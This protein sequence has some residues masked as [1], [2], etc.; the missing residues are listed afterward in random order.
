MN[1]VKPELLEHL[2][3][4]C[5][6][7]HRASGMRMSSASSTICRWSLVAEG[8]KRFSQTF[9]V[10]SPRR[11]LNRLVVVAVQIDY[12]AE[13]THVYWG[14]IRSGVKLVAAKWRTLAH[15]AFSHRPLGRVVPDRED[16]YLGLYRRGGRRLPGVVVRAK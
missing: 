11:G 12:L 13:I 8:C 15:A 6:S 3:P 5:M 16:Y 4:S 9:Y 10:I 7:A 14:Q 2:P 1:K